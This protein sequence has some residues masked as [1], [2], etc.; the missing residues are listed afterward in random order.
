MMSF[1]TVLECV[2]IVAAASVACAADYRQRVEDVQC[3]AFEATYQADQLEVCSPWPE[4]E[5]YR[6]LAI[7][8]A[9]TARSYAD[10]ANMWANNA[11]GWWREYSLLKVKQATRQPYSLAELNTAKANYDKAVAKC[12][13]CCD[14]SA[15]NS[16]V[17]LMQTGYCRV[18]MP[19]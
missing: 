12:L 19:Q 14:N 3:Q 15:Y 6:G 8:L 4:Y 18:L 2:V 1:R 11:D 5:Y 9:G 7:Q 10:A 16:R 17:S 13:E